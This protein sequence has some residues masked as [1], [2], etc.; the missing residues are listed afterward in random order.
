MSEFSRSEFSDFL[1]NDTHLSSEIGMSSATGVTSSSGSTKLDLAQQALTDYIQ[2]TICVFGILCNLLNLLILTRPKLKESPY[3]YLL[4]LAVCDLC[5]LMIVIVAVIS[6]RIGKGVYVWQFYKAFIF[7]PFGNMFTNSSIWITVLLTIERW[8]SVTFPLQA[9]KLCTKQLARGTIVGIVGIMFVINIPR[10]FCRDIVKEKI[11]NSVRYTTVSSTFEQSDLYKGI[12]WM[13]I[14]CI[15]IIPCCILTVLNTCLLYVVYR[16]NKN[17]LALNSVNE[18]NIAVHISREQR[19]LT[20]TCASIICLFLVC[21]TPT[22]IASPPV[23]FAL[24]GQD[25]DPEQFFVSSFY[26]LLTAV[27]NTLMTFNLSLNFVLY[28]FFNQ[29]FYKT[30]HHLVRAYVYRMCKINIPDKDFPRISQTSDM[31]NNNLA[32]DGCVR[33]RN[34]CRNGGTM[35]LALA[36]ANKS[37]MTH[38]TTQPAK[39]SKLSHCNNGRKCNSEE[40]L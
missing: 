25:K 20:V 28:C 3:T 33:S 32:S 1:T 35:Y 7:L 8:I 38:H 39:P 18:N 2:P 17:R 40:Y 21:A 4:G 15:L 12:T 10:F 22:A 9:K 14:I 19:R 24:F 29:K 11:N 5:V 31:G 37:T 16:A 27:T 23:A 36:P 34:S 30:F 26:R 13:Y 6:R